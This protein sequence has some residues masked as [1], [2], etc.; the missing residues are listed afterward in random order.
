MSLRSVQAF[1]RTPEVP[2]RLMRRYK[3]EIKTRK[4][5]NAGTDHC[6]PPT[7]KVVMA[8]AMMNRIPAKVKRGW[9]RK[10]I[11]K[12]SNRSRVRALRNRRCVLRINSQTNSIPATAAPYNIR[13]AFFEKGLTSGQERWRDTFSVSGF[14]AKL[15]ELR[16][17]SAIS[18]GKPQSFSA[19]ETR[20]RRERDSNPRYPFEYSGFQDRLFQPLTHPSAISK[21]LRLQQF[22]AP[23]V[24][25]GN[26]RGCILVA[27]SPFQGLGPHSG[28]AP[29]V[30]DDSPAESE[31]WVVASLT[32][33]KPYPV[34]L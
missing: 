34:R 4:T 30:A 10:R 26:R 2:C 15:V 14:L 22:T 6:N 33:G 11:G 9:A 24:V 28:T 1:P 19:L 21:M 3:S 17:L 32:T 31:D 20:W 5:E 27:H 12:S 23:S 7:K 16:E 13:K 29:G 18:R 8:I 25:G